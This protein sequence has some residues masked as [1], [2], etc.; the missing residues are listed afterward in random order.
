MSSGRTPTRVTS[1]RATKMLIAM[2]MI[3]NGQPRDAGL[4]RAVAPHRLDVDGE[5]EEHGEHRG[6][7]QQHHD[8]GARAAAR[9]EQVQRQLR[10]RCAAR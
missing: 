2:T 7:E 1:T 3:G 10:M 9:R 8:V 6:A 5:E 4:H